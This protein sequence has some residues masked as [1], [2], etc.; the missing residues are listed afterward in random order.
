MGTN[1]K[2]DEIRAFA[3][4]LWGLWSTGRVFDGFSEQFV[5]GTREDG[6]AIQALLE[7]RSI[8]PLFG[9]KI[10]A[11][12]EAGQK[13]INVAGPIAG[14]LLAER[15]RDA[16]AMIDL[17]G[18]RMR[19]AEPEFAFRLGRDIG[20]ND[21]SLSTADVLDAVETLHLAIEVPD[22]RYDDYTIVGEARL[23]ADNA[24]AHELILGPP[25]DADWR[26]LDLA[27]HKVKASVRGR[28][29]REGIGANVLGDPRV[30]L[31]W[32]VS[33]VTGLGLTVKAGQTVITGTCMVPLELQPG[34]DV[35][36]DFGVLGQID[37]L[38]APTES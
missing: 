16:G 21:R 2:S 4:R 17:T 11:T 3:D 7:T 33:E 32:L 24:C 36:A 9:W 5:P 26:T 34:D 22:S 8:N 23:I 35:T 10:A 25:T 38:V 37:L 6:Y 19:V 15:V 29:D 14:R 30:A 20:P 31:H 1:G 28:Y 13:H 27:R 18:N 12:S